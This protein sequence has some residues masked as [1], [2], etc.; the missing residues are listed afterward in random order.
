MYKNK[1][2]PLVDGMQKIIVDKII[3]SCLNERPACKA[4]YPTLFEK[5]N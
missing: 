2:H 4:A 3:T 5:V 1:C